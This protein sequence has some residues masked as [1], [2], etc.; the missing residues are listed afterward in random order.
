M[1]WPGERPADLASIPLDVPVD[2][3]MARQYGIAPFWRLDTDKGVWL[4]TTYTFMDREGGY[5]FLFE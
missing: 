4:S 2:D 1:A 3:E 5:T